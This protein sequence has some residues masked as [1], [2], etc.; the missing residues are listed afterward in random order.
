MGHAMNKKPHEISG[1]VKPRVGIAGC[2]AVSPKVM[3]MDEPLGGF[4]AL[5]RVNLQNSVIEIQ[6]ELNTTVILITHDVDEAVLMSDEIV[7][8]FNGPV[9]KVG[10]I[11]NIELDRPRARVALFNK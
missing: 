3:L 8:M 10:D 4:D 9:A 11:L 5:T 2:L 1:G 7:M 6:K